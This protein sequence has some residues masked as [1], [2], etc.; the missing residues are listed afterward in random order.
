MESRKV[1]VGDEV[2]NVL[3]RGSSRVGSDNA[4]GVRLL[5]VGLEAPGDRPNPGG[6]SYLVAER[7]DDVDEDVLRGLVTRAAGSRGPASESSPPV[8]KRGGRGRFRHR[9]R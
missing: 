5:S 8:R 3:V 1:E 7:L 4:H 9:N 6:T 2:W